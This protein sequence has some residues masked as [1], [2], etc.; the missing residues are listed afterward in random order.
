MIIK[1]ESGTAKGGRPRHIQSQKAILDAILILL[2]TEGFETMRIE[3]I[4]TAA[5]MGK[6]TIYRWWTS[7]EALA[8]DAIN[9]L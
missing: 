1:E 4:A 3:A 5:G 8:I 9:H 7:K 2:A 6:K